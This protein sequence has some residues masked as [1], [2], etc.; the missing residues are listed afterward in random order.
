MKPN[1]DV[2]RWFHMQLYGVRHMKPIIRVSIIAVSL[3]IFSRLLYAQDAVQPQPKEDAQPAQNEEDGIIQKTPTPSANIK[4]I[5]E[6]LSRVEKKDLRKEAELLRKL[7]A[8]LEAYVPLLKERNNQLEAKAEGL[9]KEKDYV[10]NET[11]GL[12]KLKGIVAKE[13]FE[14]LKKENKRLSIEI[15]KLERSNDRLQ[16]ELERAKSHQA[17]GLPKNEIENVPQPVEAPASQEAE[18]AE[19]DGE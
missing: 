2:L 15:N 9:Q 19:Y 16:A 14:K 10:V 1:S 5:K 17:K 18:P 11:K 12:K 8:E 4:E 7:N 3:L 6:E 13:D